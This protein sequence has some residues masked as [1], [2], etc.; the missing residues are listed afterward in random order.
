MR[1]NLL[2]ISATMLVGVVMFAMQAMGQTESS[3][4][5]ST[6]Y[7]FGGYTWDGIH[8]NGGLVLN[9]GYLIGTTRGGGKYDGGIIFSV[10]PNGPGESRVRTFAGNN[11]RWPTGGLIRDGSNNVYGTTMQGG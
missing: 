1:T 3:A 2:K 10:N 9:R 4:T 8:P 11:G 6:L 7:S 5:Y